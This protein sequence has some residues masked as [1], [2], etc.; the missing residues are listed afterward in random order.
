[1]KKII[2]IPIKTNNQR[3]PGKN[4]MGLAGRPLYEYIF[5][6][7]KET[8]IETYVDSSDEEILKIARKYNFNTIK[9]PVSLNSPET[10][11][12]DLI[13]HAI[14]KIEV[15][16]DYLFGQFFVTTPFIKS[17]TIKKSFNLLDNQKKYTS[18]FGT[19]E[20]FD[21]FWL[22]NE[23]VNHQPGKLVGTQYMKPLLRESGFYVFKKSSFLSEQSRITKQYTTFRVEDRECIDIDTIE[24]FVFAEAVKSKGLI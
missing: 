19:Y 8:G 5:S 4:T 2:V 15:D 7:V 11:G 3:L 16:E 1:M 21:R 10:S 18:C 9:R 6:S 17:N 12:N 13:N 14:S 23:P 22:G 20:V 24:D